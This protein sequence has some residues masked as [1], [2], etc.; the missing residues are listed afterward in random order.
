MSNYFTQS[1]K[2]CFSCQPNCI[3]KCPIW[4]EP[5]EGCK[6]D[7]TQ[8]C[9]ERQTEDNWDGSPAL[10][11]Q[12]DIRR[13]WG[14]RIEHSCGECQWKERKPPETGWEFKQ[15]T[16]KKQSEVA[17]CNTQ[18][19]HWFV[20]FCPTATRGRLS[21]I[22]TL[23]PHI[24]LDCISHHPLHWWHTADCTDC[25]NTALIKQLSTITRLPKSYLHTKLNTLRSWSSC[26]VLSSV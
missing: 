26:W 3:Q 8:A 12:N 20:V 13:R 2:E 9:Q 5:S 1:F 24:T 16:T 17:S 15:E 4:H 23:T 7:S 6:M 10:E 25:I 21:I 19:C 11:A 22:L 14:R 18:G